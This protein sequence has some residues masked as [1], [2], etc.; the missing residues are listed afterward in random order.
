MQ[1]NNVKL[2]IF[3]S[4]ATVYGNPDIVPIPESASIGNTTNPY[5]TSKY[6]VEPILNDL[7]F[8]DSDFKVCVFRYFNPVGA[9]SSGLI[10][11][12]SNG[13][14]TNLVPYISQTAIGNLEMLYVFGDDYDTKD[15]TGVCDYIHVVDLAK[16]HVCGV[17]KL[18]NMDSGIVTYNLGTGIGYSVFDVLYSFEDVN[19]LLIPYK[20]VERRPGNIDFYFGDS[21]LALEELGWEAKFDLKDMCRYAY[22][23][24]LKK[25]NKL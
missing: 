6:F 2:L 21:S 5:S 19:Q 7:C 9:H 23:Y 16:A 20:I 22:Q 3:S 8:A 25:N 13:I 15:G 14:L 10:G 12:N 4:T 18:K 17:E 24:T 11:E 1:K